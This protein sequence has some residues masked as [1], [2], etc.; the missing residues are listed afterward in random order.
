MIGLYQ[1]PP[2][3]IQFRDLWGCAVKKQ[4]RSGILSGSY[5]SRLP[6]KAAEFIQDENQSTE[7]SKPAVTPSQ[8]SLTFHLVAASQLLW[9]PL[10]QLM[11]RTQSAALLCELTLLAWVVLTWLPERF[12]TG[13][14]GWLQKHP[15]SSIFGVSVLSLFH[16]Y[17]YFR[18]SRFYP[19]SDSLL[20][21]AATCHERGLVEWLSNFFSLP[22]VGKL[23]PPLVPLLVAPVA[24]RFDSSLV[25]LSYFFLALALVCAFF[26]FRLAVELGG[27]ELGLWVFCLLLC[28]RYFWLY[29]CVPVLVAPVV[30][31]GILS[32]I[33]CLRLARG[34]GLSAVLVLALSIA[35][36]LYSKYIAIFLLPGLLSWALKKKARKGVI[37]GLLLAFLLLVPWLAFVFYEGTQSAAISVHLPLRV[38]LA[39]EAPPELH[40]SNLRYQETTA[41][42]VSGMRLDTNIGLKARLL[43]TFGFFTSQGAGILVLFILLV[44]FQ[45][46]ELFDPPTTWWLGGHL[47]L[48]L[49]LPISRYFIP[50]LPALAIVMA[51]G[52]RCLPGAW[53]VRLV[54]L[55]FLSAQMA[56]Y[57]HPGVPYV[58]LP[59]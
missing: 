31:A 21:A 46:R 37:G 29:L 49:L 25:A 53:P 20:S 43:S 59:F 58:P 39:Q 12:G 24:D 54:L 1:Q 57:Q 35:L 8:A 47:L 30:L 45:G 48:V 9:W 38:N 13:L 14:R 6:I 52:L 15:Y 4:D 27:V 51:R 11:G 41:V 50:A 16:P 17:L 3:S 33:A 36:A 2:P 32:H 5:H 28:M 55:L 18:E 10:W 7:K 23:H 34:G 56:V 22:W 19:D 42:T 44:A 40:Q 26:A